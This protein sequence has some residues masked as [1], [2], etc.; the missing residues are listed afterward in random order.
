MLSAEICEELGLDPVK[1]VSVCGHDTQSA[2]TAVPS[3]LDS[4]AFL[5]SGTWSLF[6]TEIPEPIVNNTSLSINITN[7][8]GYGGMTGLLKI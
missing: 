6:G 3:Q 1:I 7:E 2:I 8:G 5:S 4:F